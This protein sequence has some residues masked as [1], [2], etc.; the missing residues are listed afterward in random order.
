MTTPDLPMLLPPAMVPDPSPLHVSTFAKPEYAKL[1]FTYGRVKSGANWPVHCKWFKVRIPT[2]RQASALTSEPALIRSEL[3]VPSGKRPWNVERDARDPNQ[4][5]FTCS[6]PPDEPAAFDGTWNVQ[7]ELWGIEVNGGAGPVNIT[8]EESTST[9][10]ADGA[11]RERTGRGEVSKRDD[12]FYL[13]SFRPASV[14]INRNTKATLHW[15]GTPHAIYTMYYRKPNGTQGSS[16]AKDGAWTSPENLVDDTS[17]TLKATMG[18]ETRYLTTYI[19]VNNPDIIVNT[20]TAGGLIRARDGITGPDDESP[21]TVRGG[22]GLL[23]HTSLDVGTHAGSTTIRNP[24]TVGGQLTVN[25][26]TE[27]NKYVEVNAH[28]TVTGGNSIRTTHIRGPVNEPLTIDADKKG[29]TIEG[30]LTANGNVTANRD[31]TAHGNV[32]AVGADKIVRIRRLLGNGNVPLEIGS[33]TKF[34]TGTNVTF[35]GTLQV[36]GIAHVF[37]KPKRLT[38]GLN[39]TRTYTTTTSGFVIAHY[40][41]GSRG[42]VKVSVTIDGVSIPDATDLTGT[43]W[44]TNQSGVAV[45]PV[46]AGNFAVKADIGSGS[47]VDIW[48][49]AVGTGSL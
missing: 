24:L 5:V 16:T 6:P 20:A 29:V 15:E 41:S 22:A 43:Y 49:T 7:L 12:S 8:W 27:L 42:R 37:G 19:K 11:Y 18:N 28:V 23:V 48:W 40:R 25:G 47:S 4:V 33:S 39:G 3:T 35:D 46:P 38:Q 17:F 34:V 36:N 32:T 21:L 45:F 30:A 14:V 2:G 9:T 44:Q 10:G 26:E 1:T 13:H 31:V